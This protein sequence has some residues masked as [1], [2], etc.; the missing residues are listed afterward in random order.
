M[1]GGEGVLDVLGDAPASRHRGR[2]LPGPVPHRL[3][4]VPARHRR[5]HHSLRSPGLLRRDPGAV[6]HVLR[7]LS[8]QPGCI[9][10]AEVDL[11]VR[12]VKTD[13]GVLDILGGAV[14]VVDEERSGDGGHNDQGTRMA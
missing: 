8:P 5:L 10:R 12:S 9:R 4:L 3:D 11:E 7:Q 2:V 13:L 6:L 14:E 1:G